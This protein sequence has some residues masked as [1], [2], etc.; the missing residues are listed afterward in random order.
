MNK[1]NLIFATRE[2]I[3][4]TLWV[5]QTFAITNQI[6]NNKP[7][8]LNEPTSVVLKNNTQIE[9]FLI[10]ATG[11]VATVIKR[12]LTQNSDIETDVNLQ[13]PWGDWTRCYSTQLAF[14][15][16]DMSWTNTIKNWE[17]IQFW[18]NNCYIWTDDNWITLK[19]KDWTN[20]T[21]TLTELSQSWSNDKLRISNNDT[22]PSELN[23]KVTAGKWLNKNILNP[24]DNEKLWLDIN[25]D[26]TDI[27]TVTEWNANKAI[28]TN[29][30]WK[31]DSTFNWNNT[32]HWLLKIATE[33]E[34][35]NPTLENVVIDP[36]QLHTEILIT[37]TT[38]SNT[39]RASA[40]TERE[41]ADGNATKVKEITTWNYPK[42]WT[43]RITVDLRREDNTWNW[44]GNFEIR[45]NDTVVE[46]IESDSK[47]YINYA[48]D[49]TINNWDVVSLYMHRI[50]GW[51]TVFC[52]NFQMKFDE[53]SIL[54]VP[55]VNIN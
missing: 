52:R 23:N 40:N 49:I 1:S 43:I 32:K 44:G 54:R 50:N 17:K 35:K 12:G 53:V 18:W 38:A 25:V 31:I 20:A 5:G 47:V 34:S 16:F 46:T 42:W 48:R 15:L 37:W 45:V 11:W 21:R 8:E 26:D 24:W 2:V 14:N 33:I 27:F 7:V 13:K 22:T 30:S 39:L 55:V 29:W 3:S 19:F 9:R 6:E 41:S 36:K 28:K 51:Y 4:S 10:I